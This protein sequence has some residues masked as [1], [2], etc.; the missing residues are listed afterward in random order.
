MKNER[1]IKEEVLKVMLKHLPMY[2]N[3][4]DICKKTTNTPPDVEA[5]VIHLAT[6]IGVHGFILPEKDYS[7]EL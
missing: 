2:F 5:L 7:D 4:L 3:D 1:E 6:L